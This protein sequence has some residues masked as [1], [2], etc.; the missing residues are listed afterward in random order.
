[1]KNK[2]ENDVIETLARIDEKLT[3]IGFTK[4]SSKGVRL[5]ILGDNFFNKT[6]RFAR[7]EVRSYKKALLISA[8]TATAVKGHD[9]VSKIDWAFS[10]KVS[11]EDFGKVA[12]DVINELIKNMKTKSMSKNAKP[13]KN[14]ETRKH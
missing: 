4:S 12:K 1:M 11:T 2:N 5:Y 9:V 6:K 13:I 3:T 10:K 8:L 7:F 14:I